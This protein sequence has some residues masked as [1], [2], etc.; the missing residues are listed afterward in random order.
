MRMTPQRFKHLLS[1]VE[2]DIAKDSTR[3]HTI[4]PAERLAITLR[5]LA[6]GDSQQSQSFNFRVGRSTVCG[7][8]NEVCV[9]LWNKLS[10]EYL[11]MPSTAT[12]WHSMATEFEDLWN[13]PNVLGAIDGKHVAI[14]CPK[15]GGSAYY[16]YKNFN[17]IVL[18]GI[19]DP[20]YRFTFVDIGAF[21]SDNDASILNR[22]EFFQDMELGV[23][24][25]PA[26]RELNGFKFPYTFLG[27]EIFPLR[28]WLM[29]PYPGKNFT[30]EQRVFNYRLSRSRRT[31]ENT[32]GI[33]C[34]RWRIF[35]RPIR[36]DVKK[37]EAIV[38]ATV[39][40]HNYLMYTDN[41]SYTPN[42][43]IDSYADDGT[44]IHG[45]W[46]QEVEANSLPSVAQSRRNN[47]TATAKQTRDNWC[48]L[49]NSEQ[50]KLS[51]QDE[52]VENCGRVVV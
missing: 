48:L 6:T 19:C 3:R 9:A 41:A 26:Q 42:G 12:E 30:R 18:M 5:Y 44:I 7:I 11:K 47:C 45:A 43:F 28:P 20:G 33:L 15:F 21:G 31:I 8:V 32:F 49:L 50:Y 22:T 23:V 36:A 10:P 14:E 13:F 52:Y 24:P 38:K 29:K 16:N 2:E 35:R 39:C 27:D 34:A 1:L 51:W 46:R 37:V 40:L 4:S 17:S 25:L